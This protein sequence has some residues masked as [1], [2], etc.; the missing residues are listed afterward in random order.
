MRDIATATLSGNLTREVELRELPSGAAVARLRIATTTRRRTG[1]E[2]VD[3][4]NYFTVE[5]YGGHARACAEHLGK[6]SRVFVDA[7][8]D[9]RE[10]T[11]PDDH[12]REAVTFR[13]RQVLF[14]GARSTAPS[15]N[16]GSD[17]DPGPPAA[18]SA[19]D[20]SPVGVSAPSG[21]GTASAEDL[22]F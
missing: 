20:A 2:W 5:V 19:A 22:P 15:V 11:D 12:K 21:D 18:R 14:E 10:W 16:D 7:E 17:E 1:E 3:K 6:G 4:T 13:A 9:W 8:L